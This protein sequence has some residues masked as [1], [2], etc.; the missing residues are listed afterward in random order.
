[1]LNKRILLA[2]GVVIFIIVLSCMTIFAAQKEI[3]LWTSYAENVLVYEKLAEEYMKENPDVKIKVEQFPAR[4][5]EEKITITLPAGTASDIIEQGGSSLAP[6]L[7]AGWI[8]RPPAWV[9]DFVE[10]SVYEFL[11]RGL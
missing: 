5:M 11:K 7:D 8:S 9:E 3:S 2:L 1:M 10:E 6:Y 4:S